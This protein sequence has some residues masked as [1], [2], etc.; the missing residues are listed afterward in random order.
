MHINLSHCNGTPSITIPT[1]LCAHFC[2]RIFGSM[3]SS[4]C[5]AAEVLKEMGTITH[6]DQRGNSGVT[7]FNIAIPRDLILWLCVPFEDIN[8]LHGFFTIAMRKST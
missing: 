1:L 7:H 6:R 2:N 3:G 8:S 4:D 5:C